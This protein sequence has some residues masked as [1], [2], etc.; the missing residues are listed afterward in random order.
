MKWAVIVNS[1]AGGGSAGRKWKQVSSLLKDHSIDFYFLFTHDP[2]TTRELARKS[3][4]RGIDGIAVYGGDGTLSD[5]A[6]ILAEYPSGPCLAV[7]PAGSGNDWARSIGFNSPTPEAGIAAMKKERIENIDSGFARWKGGGK[8][9]LNSAGI[10]FDALVLRRSVAMKKVLPFSKPVYFMSL[11]FSA[12]LPPVWK[13]SFLCDGSEFFSGKYLTFTAGVGRYSGGGMQ[14]SPNAVPNDGLLDGLCL[15]PM[16]FPSIAA[17]LGR[18]FDGTIHRTKWAV[19]ARGRE[20]SIHP[21][22]KSSIL[23]ELDGD[24]VVLKTGTGPL[25][26][27]SVPESLSVAIP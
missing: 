4:A 11:L 14:L 6:S 3:I 27:I 16:R 2:A 9:F 8:F 22:M 13:A 18:V 17:N 15:M 19:E 24:Q 21:E 5:A 25:N 1:L 7:I 26:L 12:L 23:L 10:G 20:I